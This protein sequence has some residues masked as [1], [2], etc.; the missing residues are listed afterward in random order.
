[1]TTPAPPAQPERLLGVRIIATSDGGARMTIH[2]RGADGDLYQGELTLELYVADMLRAAITDAIPD[3]PPVPADVAEIQ[4]RLERIADTT[5]AKLVRDR[6]PHI[7]R[8]RGADPITRIAAPAE[9]RALLFAKL[10]EEAAE[11]SE[12][13]SGLDPRHVAEEAADVLEVVY[14][15]A[16]KSGVD[17]EQLEKVRAAKAEQRGGFADRIVWCGNRPATP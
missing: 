12:A 7:I 11:L 10:A 4:R 6:I 15:I 5:T 17:R 13:T 3:R 9:Y 14:A 8:A 1:M 2:T 16:A